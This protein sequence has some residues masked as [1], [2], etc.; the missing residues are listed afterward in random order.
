MIHQRNVSSYCHY[1]L[2]GEST[3]SSTYLPVSHQLVQLLRGLQCPGE[4]QHS[5]GEPVQSVDR[6]ELR[7]APLFSEDENHRVVAEAAT[8]VHRDRGGLVDHKHLTIIHQNL[9]GFADH[10]GLMAVHRVL[11]VVIILWKIKTS[12]K[13]LYSV[14]PE[15]DV[16]QSKTGSL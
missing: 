11:H 16:E 12:L 14:D 1:C 10:R 7:D 8:G 13:L 6:V 15:T 3:P 2:R 9:Q 4:K 5:R